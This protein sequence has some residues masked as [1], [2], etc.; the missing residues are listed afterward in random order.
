MMQIKYLVWNRKPSPLLL[1]LLLGDWQTPAQEE[2]AKLPG[3]NALLK[4]SVCEI[5][6]YSPFQKEEE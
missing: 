3:T 4:Q 1:L 5:C 6:A 2:L